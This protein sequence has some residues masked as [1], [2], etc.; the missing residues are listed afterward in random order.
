MRIDGG[1]AVGQPVG[2]P[3]GAPGPA[4]DGD[5]GRPVRVRLDLLVLEGTPVAV[6]DVVEVD[7]GLALRVVH[8]EGSEPWPST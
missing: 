5:D 7:C 2:R 8:D 3:A 6:G 4:A 1:E